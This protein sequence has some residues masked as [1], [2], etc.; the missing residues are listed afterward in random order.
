MNQSLPYSQ[1][2]GRKKL[3]YR[4]RKDRLENPAVVTVSINGSTDE[5]IR[6]AA[7]ANSI[8]YSEAVE[9]LV[10]LGARAAKK[11]R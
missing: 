10:I 4:R 8:S 2:P 11:K 7:E 1:S 6:S 9:R 5:I 3:K